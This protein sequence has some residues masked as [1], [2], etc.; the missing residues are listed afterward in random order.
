M[1]RGA[2]KL[3]PLLSLPPAQLERFLATCTEAELDA[4]E[5]ET[6]DFERHW[7]RPNQIEPRGPWLAWL[8]EGGRGSGKTRVGAEATHRAARENPGRHLAIVARTAPDARDTMI[9]GESGIMATGRSDF[10]PRYEPSKRRVVWPNNAWAT[11]YSAEKPDLLR[12]PN[13]CFAWA[14]EYASWQFPQ[15]AWDNLMFT[16]RTG[17]RP[18]VV[19]T[20]TPKPTPAYKRLRE[21]DTTVRSHSTMFDNVA[22]LAPS[23]VEYMK[24]RYE[25]SA[26]GRQE[27]YAEVIE[28]VA[29]ALWNRRLLEQTRVLDEG[30]VPELH[31]IVVAIDPSVTDK[32]ATSSECGIVVAGV[33]HH[34]NRLPSH[35]YVMV[36]ASDVLSPLRWAERAVGL[37]Q[38]YDAERLVGEVNHGGDLIETT[39]RTVDPNVPFKQ[40]RAS[41]N[42]QA[43]AEPISALS[44]QGRLHLVGFHA[45]LEDQ[46]CT[47]VP[48]SGMP[49][50]DRL[51]AM[52]W[53][54][55]ELMQ[56]TDVHERDLDLSGLSKVSH[57]T[58]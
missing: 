30:D 40:L 12:G 2:L 32:E 29:G 4:L 17:K 52:V 14:D 5:D 41:K 49:S 33:R 45:E 18:R 31:R 22:N 53:A 34:P 50:P 23:F 24:R 7:A 43:R 11:I 26:L 58:E 48:A 46:L 10:R 51:D 54:I 21:D 15:R 47:W 56:G 1:S 38:A 19:V 25:G 3:D 27:L 16:L 13:I 55:T 28:E 37:R 35:F 36:D 8:L 42:K 57:W 39:L 20:T 6:S 44:E 9:E